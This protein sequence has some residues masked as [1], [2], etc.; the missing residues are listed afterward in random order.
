M[1]VIKLIGI[2]Y[3]LAILH[4]CF[5]NCNEIKLSNDDRE[6]SKCYQKANKLIF[7]SDL[8][9]RDTLVLKDRYEDYTT[10]S[11][12]ELGPNVYNYL[13]FVFRIKIKRNTIPFH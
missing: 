12:F 13:G 1:K 5:S 6:W 10:C 9:H 8:N 2:I 7:L 3:C 11:K 4:S